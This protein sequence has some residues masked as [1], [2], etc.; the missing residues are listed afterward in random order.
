VVTVWISRALG[1]CSHRM[2]KTLLT[3]AVLKFGGEETRFVAVLAYMGTSLPKLAG[4]V[5]GEGVLRALEVP[6]TST[7]WHVPI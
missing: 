3:R 1:G 7:A 2:K 5:P 4:K 6:G